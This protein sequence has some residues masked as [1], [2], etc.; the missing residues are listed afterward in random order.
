MKHIKFWWVF[1]KH[2]QMLALPGPDFVGGK[3]SSYS[4]AGSHSSMPGFP[5]EMNFKA[6]FLVECA[7]I[8][9]TGGCSLMYS[10]S[11]FAEYR[12]S[13]GQGRFL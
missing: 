9:F 5:G 4:T 1:L 7:L 6:I 3:R 11:M 12:Q 13:S 10:S 8:Y 2:F